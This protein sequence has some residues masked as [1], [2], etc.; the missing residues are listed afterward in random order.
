MWAPYVVRV[1]AAIWRAGANRL[2]VAVT[3]SAA[4]RYEGAMRPSGLLGPVTLRRHGL[5]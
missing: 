5:E 3:N 1:P 2:E 4:N